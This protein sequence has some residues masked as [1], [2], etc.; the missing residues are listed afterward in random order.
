MT[1]TTE[2]TIESQLRALVRD[3][4]AQGLNVR[5][6]VVG[7]DVDQ[8]E[9]EQLVCIA[10]AGGGRYF[11]AQNSAQLQD[12]LGEVRQEVVQKAEVGQEPRHNP[13]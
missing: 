11:S 10:E 9:R 6:H 3:L 8:E 1:A 13:Q 5:V 4:R 2:T 12:A 7:F